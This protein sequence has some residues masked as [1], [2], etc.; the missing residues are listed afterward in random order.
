MLHGMKAP[1]LVVLAAGI[2]V[3]FGGS[4]QFHGLGPSGE[5]IAD[6]SL[7]DAWREGF[8]RALFV[9]REEDAAFCLERFGRPWAGRLAVETVSQRLEDLPG[10]RKPPRGRRKPWGTAHAVW[11][12]RGRVDSPFAVINADDFYG[13][14]AFAAMRAALSG[15]PGEGALVA[16][17]L[18]ETLSDS[19]GVARAVCRVSPEGWLEGIRECRGVRRTPRGIEGDS[20]GLPLGETDPVSMNFWGL[21]PQALAPFEAALDRLCESCAGDVEDE[22]AIPDAVT[23]CLE[24]GALRVRVLPS[25]RGWIGVTYREDVPAAAASLADLARSGEY[26]SPLYDS[27]TRTEA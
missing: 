5:A 26:P 14:R 10:G 24:S 20:G 9:V 1:T 16:Y 6:F 4:K 17:P 19:G 15:G 8:G 18:G 27:S 25:G 2:G 7:Y 23:G 12:V 22:L 13:R 21:P 3:R 11:T